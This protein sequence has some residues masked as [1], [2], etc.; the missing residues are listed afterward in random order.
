VIKGQLSGKSFL[1]EGIVVLESGGVLN[2]DDLTTKSSMTFSTGSSGNVEYCLT[3]FGTMT[4][5]QS[6]NLVY[7]ILY[8]APS[9]SIV[10]ESHVQ[11]VISPISTVV[12]SGTVVASQLAVFGTLKIPSNANV[13]IHIPI[14]SEANSGCNIEIQGYLTVVSEFSLKTCTVSGAGALR[15]LNGFIAKDLID[16]TVSQVEISSFVLIPQGA[17][18]HF[19]KSS[20]KLFSCF[21]NVSGHI[22]ADSQ[23]HFVLSIGSSLISQN[24]SFSGFGSMTYSGTVF[25]T[26]TVVRASAISCTAS[27]F[28]ACISSTFVAEQIMNAGLFSLNYCMYEMPHSIHVGA[29][30]FTVRNC[31][32]LANKVTFLQSSLLSCID[33]MTFEVSGLYTF[34]SSLEVL[35]IIRVV[36]VL[37]SPLEI[38]SFYPV[39]KDNGLSPIQNITGIHSQCF[40]IRS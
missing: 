2:A 21:A 19:R 4:M 17:R 8:I 10:Y 22:F 27:S 1:F 7:S 25:M 9:S 29:G 5:K 3:V 14:T 16:V 32:T 24:A 12:L 6:S 28:I 33:C 20:L 39:I 15:I 34:S 30:L 38:S 31:S 26:S 23:S 40:K 11:A 36:P 37:A 13:S 35:G 18:V